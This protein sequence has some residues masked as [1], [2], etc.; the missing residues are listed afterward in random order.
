MSVRSIA[1]G[2][3]RGWGIIWAFDAVM[4]IPPLI[5]L[6]ASRPYPE[7]G[8]AMQNYA[9]MSQLLGIAIGVGGA[10]FLIS[11]AKWLAGKAFPDEESTPV[12]FT[13]ANV[14]AIFFSVFGVYFFLDGIRHMAASAYLLTFKARL[15]DRSAVDYL[16]QQDP[17]ALL[18]AGVGCLLGIALFFGARGLREVWERYQGRPRQ[19]SVEAEDGDEQ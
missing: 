5:L 15:D 12:S 7:S 2:L 19:A 8:Q 14:Q 17:A 1:V 4:S 16:W 10:I 13:A 11:M 6:L 9:V 3:F 18:R